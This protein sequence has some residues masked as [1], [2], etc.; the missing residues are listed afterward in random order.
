M[1]IVKERDLVEV[2]DEAGD[3]ER[4]ENVGANRNPGLWHAEYPFDGACW[5]TLGGQVHGIDGS[6]SM[7]AN[8]LD[9]C[10]ERE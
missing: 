2:Q 3:G 1:G 8:G 4:N 5:E 7:Q 10:R 6:N 9:L